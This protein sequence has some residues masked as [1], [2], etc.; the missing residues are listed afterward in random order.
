MDGYT[1]WKIHRAIKFHLLTPKYDLFE[2]GGRTKNTGIDVYLA[3]REKTY[4]EYIAKQFKKP[5]DAVQFFVANIAYTGRDAVYEVGEAWENYLLWMKHKE[6]LTKMISDELELVDLTKDIDGNPPKLLT[7]ILVGRVHP[8]TA[9]AINRVR[10][11]VDVWLDKA[12]LGAG[13]F[14]LIIKKM[15]RFVK[16]NEEAITLKMDSQ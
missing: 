14:P 3:C 11:F 4:F 2:H 10:P 1:A 7:D 8:Q 12:Y 16:Y 13:K 6:S 15:D 9:V 5:N